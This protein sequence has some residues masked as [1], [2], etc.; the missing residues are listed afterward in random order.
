MMRH[1]LWS[2]NATVSKINY[3]KW[4][5]V[6]LPKEEGGLGIRKI[7]EVNEAAFIK[8]RWQASTANSPWACWFKNRYFKDS[9]VWSPANTK[10]GSCIWKKSTDY[11]QHPKRK[12]LDRHLNFPEDQRLAFL[13]LSSRILANPFL[14]PF[15]HL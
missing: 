1:F 15:R 14:P 8:L 13:D 2:G 9:S 11:S 5:T 10:Y 4:E 6:S 12:L 7:S 3:V